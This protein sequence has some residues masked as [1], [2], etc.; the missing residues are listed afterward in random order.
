MERKVT[1]KPNADFGKIADLQTFYDEINVNKSFHVI[2][3]GSHIIIAH[4]CLNADCQQASDRFI[5]GNSP[6]A[7]TQYTVDTEASVIR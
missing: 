5:D 2:T 4:F 1:W 3:N 6:S 7:K